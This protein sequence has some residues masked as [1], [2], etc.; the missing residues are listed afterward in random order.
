MKNKGFTLVEL[1]IVISVIGILGGVS[2]QVINV[3]SQRNRA[4]D[5]IR[6][7]NLEK[8]VSSIETYYAAEDKYPSNK[9]DSVLANYVTHWPDGSPSGSTYSYA[10]NADRSEFGLVVDLALTEDSYKYRSEWGEIKTC[11]NDDPRTSNCSR[12]SIN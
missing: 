6:L 7:S 11:V 10:T 9:N 1:L 5:S 12:S 4:E 2:M 8:L 3:K